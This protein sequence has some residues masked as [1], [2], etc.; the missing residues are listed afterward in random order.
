MVFDFIF[1]LLHGNMKI[2][3]IALKHPEIFVTILMCFC[4]VMFVFGLGT[5][6]FSK[7]SAFRFSRGKKKDCS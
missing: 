6:L 3:K 4:A 1:E 2:I 5:Y 7:E